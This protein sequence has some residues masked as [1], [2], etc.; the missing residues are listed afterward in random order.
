M[1][2]LIFTYPPDYVAAAIAARQAARTGVE[3]VLCIDSRDPELAVDGVR[4]LRTDF[5]RVGN[6]NGG[7]CV[8]GILETMLAEADGERILKLDSDTML[9]G[10]DWLKGRGEAVVGRS[11]P[12]RALYGFCYSIRRDALAAMLREAS[13][14]HDPFCAEDRTM[15]ELAGGDIHTYAPGPDCPLRAY[16]WS[17]APPSRWHGC[18]AVVFHPKPGKGR[19][20]V[21]DAMENLLR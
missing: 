10:L 4:V 21:A 16:D 15:A 17:D 2:A 8:R 6:L 20:E 13:T 18:G 9:F 11:S 5:P 19:R 3:P 7:A 14:I 12:D 1:K